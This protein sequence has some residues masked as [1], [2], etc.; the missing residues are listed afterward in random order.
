M[1]ICAFVQPGSHLFW[2][3]NTAFGLPLGFVVFVLLVVRMIQAGRPGASERRPIDIPPSEL[4]FWERPI[5]GSVLASIGLGVIICLVLTLVI[6]RESSSSESPTPLSPTASTSEQTISI[7]TSTPN[8]DSAHVPTPIV[9]ESQQAAAPSQ[10]QQDGSSGYPIIHS[11][12]DPI[13]IRD[14]SAD[15]IF[16]IGSTRENVVSV[17]GQ[18]D[19]ASDSRFSYGSSAV[20]FEDGKVISWNDPVGILRVGKPKLEPTASNPNVTEFGIGSTKN[21]V[22]AVMGQPDDF[23]DTKYSYGLSDIYFEDG[24]VKSWSNAGHNLRLS[25]AAKVP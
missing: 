23:T 10:A 16:S 8:D 9:V 11:N 14:L 25:N 24:R 19:E 4:P 13:I 2:T 6:W 15:K 3:Q 12:I 5:S 18:P 17:Q 20:Y 22:L 7:T 21:E 1:P